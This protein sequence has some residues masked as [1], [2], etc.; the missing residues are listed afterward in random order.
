[1][2]HRR[3]FVD[4]VFIDV[5]SWQT[6]VQRE[7]RISVRLD[8]QSEHIP[9]GRMHLKAAI[10]A[11]GN[12]PD[13]VLRSVTP[14][15]AIANPAFAP[16]SWRIQV[17]RVAGPARAPTK[18]SCITPM[19]DTHARAGGG[20]DHRYERSFLCHH[21]PPTGRPTLTICVES[22]QIPGGMVRRLLHSP[23]KQFDAK[24][25]SRPCSRNCSARR[26][27]CARSISRRDYA[28]MSAR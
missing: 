1:M 6:G 4:E 25:F 18:C 3:I 9:G 10:G 5:G 7:G 23:R 26:S 19:L 8:A 13:R 24:V 17:D 11:C 14:H 15:V 20:S 16:D 27:I 2:M 28:R 21:E 22:M 12:D